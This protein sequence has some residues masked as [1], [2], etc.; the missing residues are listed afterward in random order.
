M[1]LVSKKIS[2]YL[3]KTKETYFASGLNT[4][5]LHTISH[6]CYSMDAKETSIFSLRTKTLFSQLIHNRREISEC[7]FNFSSIFIIKLLPSTEVKKTF[8]SDKKLS[9]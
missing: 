3:T 1:F 4:T 7:A 8:L 5:I 9:L 6:I 2:H